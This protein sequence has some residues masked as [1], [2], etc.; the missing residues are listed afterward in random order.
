MRALM[1]VTTALASGASWVTAATRRG[2]R[3]GAWTRAGL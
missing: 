1:R 2:T 3:A